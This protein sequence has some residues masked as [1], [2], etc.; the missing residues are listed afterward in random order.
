MPIGYMNYPTGSHFVNADYEPQSYG[1]GS[2][3]PTVTSVTE[4]LSVAGEQPLLHGQNYAEYQVAGFVEDPIISSKP[5]NKGY[6]EA[7][8]P[9]TCDRCSKVVKRGPD[10]LRHLR[11]QHPDDGTDGKRFE[12]HVCNQKFKRRGQLQDHQRRRG[13]LAQV[14]TVQL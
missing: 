4:S 8:V 1:P 7:S 9:I 6:R 10:Y 13:H 12:C 5:S 11:E 14:I 3:M 2:G